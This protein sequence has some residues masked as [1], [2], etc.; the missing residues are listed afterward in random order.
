MKK[1]SLIFILLFALA[2][3]CA[4][5]SG[6]NADLLPDPA[7]NGAVS[8]SPSAEETED[9]QIPYGTPAKTVI[10]TVIA[11]SAFISVLLITLILFAKSRKSGVISYRS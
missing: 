7:D 9:T 3:P 11:A 10:S 8:A 4:A 1:L 5:Q 6:I 2:L